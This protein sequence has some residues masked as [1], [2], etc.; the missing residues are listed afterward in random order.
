MKGFAITGI[1]LTLSL[2]LWGQV[3]SKGSTK[4]GKG[5]PKPAPSFVVKDIDGKEMKLSDFKG[6]IVILNFWATWCR[7]CLAEIPDFVVLQKKYPKD[8][9]IIGLSV[10]FNN[11]AGVKRFIRELKIN[12][13]IAI[14]PQ[15]VMRSYGG[16][17]AIPSTFV[18]DR[19]LNIRQHFLGFR[20]KDVFEA[21]VVALGAAS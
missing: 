11:D 2:A 7:P 19:D 6:K 12:Y 15:E 4:E 1:A 18:L 14:A 21:Q 5:K 8:V 16:V 13:P 9:A 3:P 20:S 10:D 17:N